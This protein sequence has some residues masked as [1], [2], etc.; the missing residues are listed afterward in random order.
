MYTAPFDYHAPASLDEVLSLLREHGDDA[1][2]LAGGHSLIPVMKLRFAQPKH[3]VDL[4]KVPGLVGIREE[5]GALVIGAMTTYASVQASDLVDRRLP[6]LAEAVRV[7]GDPLVRNMGTVGG[8]L[9]H[10]DPGA[11]LPALALALD[12][13]LRVRGRG[14]ERTVNAEDFFVGLMETALRPTDI[15]TEVRFQ[16]PSGRAGAAYVKQKHPASG[17][18]LV[19]VAAVVRLGEGDRIDWARVALTGLGVQ[20]TRAEPVEWAL[21]G[22][23]VNDALL[24]DAAQHAADGIEIRED[25]QGTRAYKANLAAVCARRA[26]ARALA[27]ARGRVD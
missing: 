26:L 24:A 2:L 23:E 14:G 10:A 18:A 3:L 22:Q 11:D 4:R 16:I 27:R 17:Y 25:L 1:K 12:A 13:E 19:G 9:A 20:P 6:V 7:I 5:E 8:S 15:L 21:T